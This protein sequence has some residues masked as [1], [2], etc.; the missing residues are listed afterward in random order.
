V[1][2]RKSGVVV[3]LF[4]LVSSRSWGVGEFL[5]LPAFAGWV[6]RAGQSFVQV[7]PIL[8]IPDHET[9]PYSALTAMAL[10]P[11]YISLGE[12]EDFRM[13]G[14]VPRLTG[15]DRAAVAAIQGV[16]RVQHRAVRALKGRWLRRGH[17]RFL[18]DEAGPQSPRFLRFDAFTEREAWWLDDY[19]LFRALRGVHR[20]LAWWEWPE[21]LARRHEDALRT[22][23]EELAVE[24]G[25]RKYV[26]W[27][28]AEQWERART[29][30]APIQVFG[31]VPFMISADSADV[32]SQQS[33]FRLDAN[34]GVPP[35]A[36]SQNG[37]DWGLPPWR[38][39]AM[40]QNDFGW[41][42]RRARRSAALF[43][44]F[45]LDH[46]VGLYR[47]F[48]RPLDPETRP[49]FAP[50]DEAAEL[51]LG[52]R[53]V[54][55]Y[56]D[57]G[58][59]ITAEDLGTVPDFVRASIRRLGV[60]GYKVLRWERHWSRPEQPFIDPAEY[61][62]VS[63]ATTGTHDTEALASWWEALPQD[64]R[65]RI[66]TLPT[67]RRF[68]RQDAAALPAPAEYTTAI[69]DALIRA[70][71]ASGSR[72]TIFPFQDLFGW[73]VRI[74][75]PATVDEANWSWRLPWPVD[76]LESLDEPRDRAEQLGQWTRDA[77][78]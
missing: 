76:E 50:P 17:E 78:R 53:L 31:D 7:L 38:W 29:E 20:Q 43:D 3:P 55:I 11:I 57:S 63:V 13:I 5:D 39:E 28:A 22:A 32:W 8:E 75:T 65:D 58:A 26:Q 37:Q 67:V 70:L 9:S 25:Y 14:G 60:P 64:D 34:V 71:L 2:S 48:I 40:A 33:E 69:G 77:S 61:D 19:A 23:S 16:P 41:M 73:P 6:G 52:E 49:F 30:A 42:R 15:D 18:H 10:D 44:G 51:D 56:Q 27:V 1:S 12:L 66:V 62:E 46:L 36:F 72:L 74:N 59:E 24:I 21:P 54:R 35:D 4:S 45:R 68:L 47:T